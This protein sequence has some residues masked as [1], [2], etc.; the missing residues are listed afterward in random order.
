[1]LPIF[2]SKNNLRVLKIELLGGYAPIN[3]VAS[4][5]LLRNPEINKCGFIHAEKVP[6][7]DVNPALNHKSCY[8]HNKY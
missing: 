6:F 3:N 5:N 1:M 4:A 8:L 2:H 7:D